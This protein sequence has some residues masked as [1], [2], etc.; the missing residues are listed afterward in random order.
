MKYNSPA[1]QTSEGKGTVMK[2]CISF[3]KCGRVRPNNLE[4]REAISLIFYIHNTPDIDRKI[5][6][7]DGGVQPNPVFSIIRLFQNKNNPR[8]FVGLDR[9]ICTLT[10]RRSP[11]IP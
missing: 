9:I 8:F 5:E 2:I 1:R 7:L 4:N 3:Q 10:D 6:V 11:I